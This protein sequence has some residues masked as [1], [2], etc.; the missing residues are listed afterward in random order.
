MFSAQ[1]PTDAPTNIR[2]LY[3]TPTSLAY[4]FDQVSDGGSNGVITGYRVYY[5]VDNGM[6]GSTQSMDISKSSTRFVLSGL[7]E[8][9]KYRVWMTAVNSDGEGPESQPTI[10]MTTKSRAG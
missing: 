8:N 7:K 10:S 3:V 1:K 2:E 6:Q 5:R 9:I 4:G